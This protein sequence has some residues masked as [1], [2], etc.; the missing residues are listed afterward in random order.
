M[1]G[2]ALEVRGQV[3][4]SRTQPNIALNR[5]AVTAVLFFSFPCRARLALR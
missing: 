2:L 3:L 1:S 4:Q 5:N